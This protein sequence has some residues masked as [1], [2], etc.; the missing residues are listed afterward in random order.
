M[1]RT[2]F[3]VST[4]SLSLALL[5][6][7]TDTVSGPNHV[8][9]SGR[10][11]T[12]VRSVEGFDAIAL[13]GAGSLIIEQTG[14]ESLE[15]EAEDNVMP[16][17][18]TEV[19]G[20]RL[21]LGLAPGADVASHRSIVYRLSVRNL[22]AIEASGASRIE[23]TGVDGERLWL[24]LSGSSVASISGSVDR[25]ELHLSGA[26]LFGASELY[27]RVAFASLSGVCQGRIR[28]SDRLEAH[29]SGGSVLEYLGDPVVVS[30]VS[31]G[32]VVRRVGP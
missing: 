1:K 24:S 19:R 11:V 13:S 28:V 9:G 29:A 12:E 20:G 25:L 27:S 21:S 23:L 22:E 6:G 18:V 32:S 14:F 10:V 8:L 26:S 17:V 16:W 15:V 30:S 3:I 5:G 7:C 31:G 4:A 2:A